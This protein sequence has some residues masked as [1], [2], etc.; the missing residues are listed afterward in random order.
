M[1]ARTRRIAKSVRRGCRCLFCWCIVAT[2]GCAT[3]R[4]P[5]IHAAPIVKG[6]ERPT[7]RGA[8]PRPTHVDDPSEPAVEPRCS[9][10]EERR[11]AAASSQHQGL[12]SYYA[13]SLSGRTM[14]NGQAY[15]PSRL[16]M[17]HR[18]LPFGT[19]VRVVRIATGAEVVV[20]VTD[21][22]PFGRKRRIADLSKEAARRLGMIRAGVVE[23]RLEVL[24][25]GAPKPKRRRS[26]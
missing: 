24:S 17:A 6:V 11:D 10:D 5:A 3:S 22:G 14:A 7:R 8:E 1:R 21:R 19:M 9:L 13:D 12:A 15:R 2:V 4:R 16:T 20:C 26:R 25:L 18:T 23:V